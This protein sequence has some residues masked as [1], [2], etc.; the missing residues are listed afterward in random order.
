M[1]LKR[2]S[3]EKKC[4]KKGNGRKKGQKKGGAAEKKCLKIE[5]LGWKR[6]EK[7]YFC[8]VV[9][10]KWVEKGWFLSQNV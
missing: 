4:L 1:G 3:A 7:F 2:R 9:C 6:M 10:I 8:Y 5:L